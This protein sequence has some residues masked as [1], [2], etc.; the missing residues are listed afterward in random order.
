VTEVRA[1]VVNRLRSAILNIESELGLQPSAT[2]GTVKDRLD[3]L[4]GNITDIYVELETIRELL[5]SI[6]DGYGNGGGGVPLFPINV[7]LPVT[8]PGQTSFNLTITPY[9]DDG[10]QMF[11]NGQK[12]ERDVDYTSTGKSV[13]YLGTYDLQTS[14]VIEFYYLY[15]N[16]DAEVPS[17]VPAEAINISFIAGENLS[18]GDVVGAFDDAGTPKIFKCDA[19]ESNLPIGISSENYLSGETCEISISGRVFIP[20]IQWDSLPSVSNV[21]SAVY[22]HT[23]AGMLS[24]TSPSSPGEYS[25]K[26]GVLV[27]GGDDNCY[28]II[29]IGNSIL[30]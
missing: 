8:S 28:I 30:N 22:L 9:V 25:I 6:T 10:V 18:A 7:S 3:S 15:I 1:E 19:N 17:G 12:L 2:F 11:R 23:T 5:L 24:L 21:G 29:Q 27:S 26:C 14:D 13:T 4:D 16:S 20:N